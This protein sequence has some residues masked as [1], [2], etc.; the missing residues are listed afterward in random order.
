MRFPK[1]ASPPAQRAH[2]LPRAIAK[3]YR[4]ATTS[5]SSSVTW[6]MAGI[7]ATVSIARSAA[8]SINFFIC[9]LLFLSTRQSLQGVAQTTITL[10]NRVEHYATSEPN[11]MYHPQFA[12]SL[13]TE[14]APILGSSPTWV[15]CRCNWGSFL[16][17]DRERPWQQEFDPELFERCAVVLLRNVFHTRVPL[18]TREA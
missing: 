10:S 17:R 13:S 3:S 14:L 8:N 5:S 16:P 6:A 18:H 15:L 11:L 4:S 12:S 9:L 1:E 7:A 2:L